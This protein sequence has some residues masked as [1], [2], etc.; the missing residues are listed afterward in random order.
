V[1]L[2]GYFENFQRFGHLEDVDVFAIP[3]RKTPPAAYARCQALKRRGMKISCPTLD[4]QEDFLRRVG[5]LPHLVPYDSDNRRNVGYLMALES[6]NEFVI[7]IDDDN[8]CRSDEDLFLAHAVV[9]ERDHS[10]QI[11]STDTGWFNI[12]NLLQLD[13]PGI[14]YPRGFPYFARHKEEHVS[15][16]FGQVNVHI[17][18]GLWLLDPDLDAITWLVA[19]ARA[20]AFNNESLILGQRTWS[21]INT[22]NTALRRDVVSAYYFVKMGYPL[23]GM[24][25]DRYGDIFSG[26]FSQACVRHMGGAVRVGTP[27]AEH[28]RN[29]HNFMKDAENEWP[30]IMVLEDLLPWLVEA[31]LEGKTYPET[32]MSLSYA[33]Q[34]AVEQMRGKVWTEATRGY[35]HQMAF[36]MREW[37]KAYKCIG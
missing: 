29:S 11:V 36:C 5:F 14:T 32:Y 18:A 17:N 6:G 20:V 37:T 27:V 21:P 7:S 26:Y 30:C 13:C 12:C 35:F 31:K 28:K 8:Y 3:D 22:Q 10:S 2:E 25:I 23:A 34:D 33:V 24:F 19:P 9:C 16:T 1:V 4:E 15:F